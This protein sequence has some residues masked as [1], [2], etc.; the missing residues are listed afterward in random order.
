MKPLE[1]QG[2]T[3][4]LVMHSPA[5]RQ[6]QEHRVAH[7][8]GL[9]VAQAL[10]SAQAAWG[11][12]EEDMAQLAVSLWGEPVNLAKA[13]TVG[14][15]LELS[16]PLRVDPKVARRERFATQGSRGAG[17]FSKRRPGAKPGY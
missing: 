11:Q 15:R 17:L 10:A 3:D 6:V 5:H 16:R 4:V 2:T 9:T 12:S 7:H 14:D 8:V 13:L 1:S